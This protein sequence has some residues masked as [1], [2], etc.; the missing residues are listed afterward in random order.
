VAD[1]H[2]EDPRLASVYDPLDPDRSD[3][4][5]YMAI[6]DEFAAQS[7]LDVGCGTGTF[8][9]LLANLGVSVI[10]LD[11]A[12]ASLAVARTKLGASKVHWIQGDVTALPPLQVELATM[13]GNVAQVFVDDVEWVST[14]SVIRAAL[15]PQG[16]LVFESRIPED[17]AWLRWRRE[18]S[19]T[20]VTIPGIGSLEYWVEVTDV[21]DGLVSFLSTFVFEQDGAVLTSSSTLRFRSEEELAVSL[22]SAGMSVMEFRDAPD[23]PGREMVFIAQSRD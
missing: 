4:G 22:E 13:T 15:T 7:V 11:P 21:Q 17:R 1:T 5:V 3:L 9:C 10:G 18:S 19:L 6:V 12:A 14:L 23:R 2:F 8:A 16:H 20:R